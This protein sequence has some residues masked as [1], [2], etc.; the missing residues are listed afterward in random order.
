MALLV[1]RDI[2]KSFGGIVALSQLSLAIDEGE[3]V[4]LVGPNG[5]G[6][7]TL[8]NCLLGL[9]HPDTGTVI[10]DGAPIDHLPTFRRTRLGIGRTFQRLELFAGMTPREH[11]LVTE[12]VR[13]GRGRLW[14]DLLGVGRPSR[15]E[16]RVTDALLRLVGL[17]KEADVPV[18]ALSLGHGRLVELAR[19]LVGEPRLLMLDE[20]SSGLDQIERGEL[21]SILRRVR[22]ERGATIVLV[23]HDLEMVAASTQ[24]LVVLDFGRLIADGPV[25]AVLDDPAVRRAYLGQAPPASPA[26]RAEPGSATIPR[27]GSAA[28]A[29]TPKEAAPRALLELHDVDVAYGPYRAV[30]G[31]SFSVAARSAVALVGSNGA[32]KSTVARVVSGLVNPSGGRIV[33]DGRDI[34]GWPAWRIAR[35]GIAHAPEGRSVFASLTVEENLA[36]DFRRSVGPRGLAEALSRAYET[37]P[38]LGERRGQLA[39]TLSGGEQRMLALARVLAVPQR[40]LVVD[41]LSLGLSPAIVDEVFV[42]LGRVLESGTALLVIEQHVERVLQL[43]RSVVVLSAG[44]VTF[45]GRSDDVREA[46]SPTLGPLRDVR[47]T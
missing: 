28:V 34:T 41:E 40:L 23:E 9:E 15:E 46:A 4:G 45:D 8:F 37:Y 42:A 10:F 1:A 26:F 24:R 5:A 11:V 19:A 22:E 2:S 39:G 47:G 14:R 6:K 44:R 3:A 43:A 13:G 30:F 21:V 17:E 16:R 35:L 31:V 25:D 7:T 38:R 12:R 33:F 36:L 27:V 32:G 18:E 20:P 29:P